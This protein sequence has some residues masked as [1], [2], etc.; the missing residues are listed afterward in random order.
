MFGGGTTKPLGVELRVVDAGEVRL[1]DTRCAIVVEVVGEDEA[2]ADDQVEPLGGE[3]A[4]AR[5]AVAALA[6]LDVLGLDAELA[7][8]ASRPA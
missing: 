5:L 2:D 6:R 7:H 8:R 3:Q 4:D 1:R